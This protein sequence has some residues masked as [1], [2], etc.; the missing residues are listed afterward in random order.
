MSYLGCG[1]W[2]AKER[3]AVSHENTIPMFKHGGGNLILWGFYSA[4]EPNNPGKVNRT[5]SKEDYIKIL[6]AFFTKLEEKKH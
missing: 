3:R 5:T 2:L 4:N 1:F 6:V